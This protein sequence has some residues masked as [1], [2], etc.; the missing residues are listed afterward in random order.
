MKIATQLSI[1]ALLA[2]CISPSWSAQI[3]ECE[4]QLGNRTFEKHCPPGTKSLSTKN[5][6][7]KKSKEGPSLPSLTM[8]MI[9]EC[10][11]CDEM[12]K[13][14]SSKNINITEKNIKDN[15]ELQQELKIKTDGDLRVPVLIIGEKIISGYDAAKLE[16]ALQQAGYLKEDSNT[17]SAE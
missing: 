7:V 17:A 14:L 13:D 2:L 12:R 5:Y 4:D 16:V 8:Y 3:H 11:V 15:G 1:L 9:P 6:T 10:E